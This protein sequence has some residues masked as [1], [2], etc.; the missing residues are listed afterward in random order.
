MKTSKGDE[1][2]VGL[3]DHW[4]PSSDV[5]SSFWKM[6]FE[7]LRPS[8]EKVCD[9]IAVNNFTFYTKWYTNG[10]NS[11][12]PF[13]ANH[14]E[15][16]NTITDNAWGR[17]WID[18]CHGRG[19]SVGA[20]LQCY[21]FEQ[22]M[23]PPESLLGSWEGTNEVTG[24]PAA[25]EVVDPTWDGYG[26]VL[27]SMVEEQLRVFPDLD[28]IFVEFEGIG[29]PDADHLLRRL[30]EEADRA[31]DY[32]EAVLAHADE[33][34]QPCKGWTWTRPVQERL[35]QTLVQHLDIVEEVCQRAGFM[36][37]RGVVYQAFNYE[38]PYVLDCLPNKD[39]WLLPWNYWGFDW[40]ENH[41]DDIVRRQIDY[42]KAKFTQLV[43]DDWS[44][45]YVGNASLPTNRPE[46]IAELARHCE[47][48]G[49]TG[50]LGMGNFLPLVGLRWKKATDEDMT[51][52]V[53]LNG[54]GIPSGRTV[55]TAVSVTDIA[56]TVAGLFG[57]D[58]PVEWIGRSITEQLG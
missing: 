18:W 55:D 41:P 17:Q 13:L 6:S 27:E 20:M 31:G 22:G 57:P 4:V 7:E 28:Q 58:V 32:S 46:T 39:W 10:T 51:I 56:P 43:D 14:P 3:M 36:G 21:T 53:I 54:R 1:T 34:G 30:G 33:L 29:G 15:A 45:Y 8:M 16:S 11:E 12:L 48:I 38:V 52:P 44:L 26:K 2:L 47:E 50:H 19:I 25:D 49:A 23:M 5:V 35:R 24:L 37:S 42:C 40:C 9:D